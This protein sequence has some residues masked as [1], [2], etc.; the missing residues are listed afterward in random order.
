[1]G[2]AGG[3]IILIVANW[4]VSA[5]CNINVRANG[6]NGGN[7]SNSAIHGG[8]G[9]GGQGAIFYT[10]SAP[11]N[12]TNSTLQGQGG[13]NN[14]SC[15]SRAEDGENM[16]TNIFYNSYTPLPVDILNFSARAI[17]NNS[18]KIDWFLANP[19]Q[20]ENFV[21]ERS[22]DML[23]WQPIFTQKWDY[24]SYHSYVD[25]QIYNNIVHYRLKVVD[26]D[27]SYKH[28]Q[29]VSVKLGSKNNLYIYPNPANEKIFIE[30]DEDIAS[31]V[32]Q[33]LNGNRLPAITESES[34]MKIINIANLRKG[35]YIL[36]VQTNDAI[37]IEK[38]LVQR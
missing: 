28:S 21:L 33:D 29:I 25:D 3:S 11:A 10:S 27:N 14:F 38:I 4:S 35:L 9:G 20:V 32:L 2:G 5:S 24:K 6:A 19:I 22:V 37:W 16:G 26:K 1:G 12:V 31:I 18:I 13:C 17:S 34:Q 23:L 30:T 8:G 15:T 36:Q 7:V